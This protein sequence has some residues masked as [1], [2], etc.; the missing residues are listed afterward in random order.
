MSNRI[1][2]IDI[3]KQGL[4]AVLVRTAL[5]GNRIEDH[6]FVSFNDAP[7]E[8][9]GP[10]ERLAWAMETVI[11]QIP[12]QGV[13][14]LVSIA[15]AEVSFRNLQVPFKD[16]RKIRQ[17]LDF[18]LEPTLPVE[19]SAM[20]TD[21]LIVGQTEQT[22]LIVAAV[23]TR[24]LETIEEIFRRLDLTPRTITIGSAA[25]ALC[26]ARL[27]ETGEKNFLLLDIDGPNAAACM[28]VGGKIHM[29]RALRTSV[30]A[31]TVGCADMIAAGIQ[32]MLASF[33]TLYEA[34]PQLGRVFVS[35]AEQADNSFA[36]RLSRALET[37]VRYLNL[38]AETRLYQLSDKALDI[39]P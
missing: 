14:C 4:C 7:A 3:R 35:G 25:A 1:L 27:S 10:E 2:S 22:D 24:K 30:A 8:A 15:A 12:A 32:R 31:D 37:E 13:G 26:V 29:I 36:E 38:A 20:Q 34:D 18:E 39:G 21:F 17:V 5:K 19:I 23:E 33:E 16:N 6:R 11:G 9:A 28:V